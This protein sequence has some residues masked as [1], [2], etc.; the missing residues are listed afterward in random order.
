MPTLETYR[1]QAKL[2]LRWHRDGNY[3]VGERIRRIERYRA[4]TD[5]EVMALK[6]TL[7]MAQEIVAFEA[8]QPSWAELKIAAAG[9]AKAPRV[10]GGPLVLKNVTPILLVRDVKECAAF[11]EQ[12]LGFR[13]DFLYGAPPFYGA[14]SRGGAK[15]HMRCVAQP[16]FA[17]TWAEEESLI[18]ATIEVTDVRALFQEFEERGVEFVQKIVKQPWG[19]TDFQVS[20]PDGNV[21]SF[22]TYG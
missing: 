21:I 16:W 17:K 22:V 14:V 15:L 6:F 8:G 1:K 2:L 7:T 12:K 20:D 4:M 11:F 13:I 9:A 19:G 10:S 3:T 18:Y 5:D